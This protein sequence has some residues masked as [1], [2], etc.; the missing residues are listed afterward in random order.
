MKPTF[1][2]RG[3][4]QISDR[5]Q[6]RNSYPCS[7]NRRPIRSKRSRFSGKSASESSLISTTCRL[8]PQTTRISGVYR[9]FAV[10]MVFQNEGLLLPCVRV[11][12]RQQN[13][14]CPEFVLGLRVPRASTDNIGDFALYAR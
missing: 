13:P 1:V 12:G 3:S 9:C 14:E 4:A 2:K 6:S 8:D 7:A 10:V 5:F 11:C